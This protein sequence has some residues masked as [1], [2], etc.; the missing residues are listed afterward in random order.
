MK[1]TQHAGEIASANEMNFQPGVRVLRALLD[2]QPRTP[3]N[4]ASPRGNAIFIIV[5]FLSRPTPSL[6]IEFYPHLIFSR[7]TVRRFALQQRIIRL[8]CGYEYVALGAFTIIKS[9]LT[10]IGGTNKGVARQQSREYRF[11]SQRV[12]ISNLALRFLAFFSSILRNLDIVLSESFRRITS[13][14]SLNTFL[15]FFPILAIENSFKINANVVLYLP[16]RFIPIIDGS[17][18]TR[19]S[20]PVRFRSKG[21]IIRNELDRIAFE[22]E[23]HSPIRP[24]ASIFLY[25]SVGE[26]RSR[27]DSLFLGH[28]FVARGETFLVFE[29]KAFSDN[30]IPGKRN[31]LLAYAPPPS[32][33]RV[34]PLISRASYTPIASGAS[35]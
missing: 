31:F 10:A 21:C 30:P 19:H 33:A 11:S 35:L 12:A 22:K 23:R 29:L 8:I 15:I 32:L 14:I 26:C 9:K 3:E 25:G 4:I 1:S 2:L 20:S 18:R 27:S 34:C 5:L 13:I 24:R 7:V 17:F 16:S 6:N 28:A